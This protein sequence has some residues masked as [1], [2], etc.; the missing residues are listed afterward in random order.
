MK[1]FIEALLKL[2]SK[3]SPYNYEALF[4]RLKPLF[5]KMSEKQK[6]GVV[7]L[8]NA[9]TNL[10]LKQKAYVLATVYHETAKTM[11][12]ITEYG[13]VKYFDKLL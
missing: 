7:T 2:F 13:G 1:N 11:Q 3:K 6:E 8:L 5:P 12:P 4:V 9:M 10:P